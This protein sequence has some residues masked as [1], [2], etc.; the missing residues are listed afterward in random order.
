MNRIS[1]KFIATI[2]IILFLGSALI[3]CAKDDEKAWFE[4]REPAG[5]W[6]KRNLEN[7]EE[8]LYDS[9]TG[10]MILKAYRYAGVGYRGRAR[11]EEIPLD[12]YLLNKNSW[13]VIKGEQ[14]LKEKYDICD[15]SNEKFTREGWVAV[16]GE[17]EIAE[18]YFKNDHGE[19]KRYTPD[20]SEL[21]IPQGYTFYEQLVPI[22]EL[23]WGT[24]E[25]KKVYEC[26]C[27]SLHEDSRNEIIEFCIQK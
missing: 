12:E 1:K 6:E 3:S 22:I 4:L 16:F 5:T 13:K 2:M 7:G 21:V 19:L 17:P 26:V 23:K 15:E 11:Y 24:V 20:G 27:Y 14:E 8:Y 9:E 25:D 18:G 10:T